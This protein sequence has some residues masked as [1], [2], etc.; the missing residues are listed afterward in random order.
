VAIFAIKFSISIS[1]DSD[2]SMWRALV[3]EF[4]TDVA[5][6]HLLFNNTD[7]GI[8]YRLVDFD[9]VG[10]QRQSIINVDGGF[11]GGK[12]PLAA[13]DGGRWVEHQQSC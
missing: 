12:E 4:V 1:A 7:I 13:S 2:E 5:G 10:W 3:A 9:I 6:L 8:D 11:V